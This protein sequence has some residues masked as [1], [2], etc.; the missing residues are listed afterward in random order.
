MDREQPDLAAALRR[1]F[2][3]PT[4]KALDV[5]VVVPPELLGDCVL[6]DR[7]LDGAWYRVLR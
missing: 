4:R 2:R 5:Q 3:T 7:V 6:D 1:A